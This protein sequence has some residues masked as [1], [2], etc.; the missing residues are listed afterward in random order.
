MDYTA[1]WRPGEPRCCGL[2]RAARTRILQRVIPA[3][4]PLSYQGRA[5]SVRGRRAPR[6]QAGRLNRN[7]RPISALH[8]RVAH[9]P[10]ARLERGADVPPTF[11][12]RP[13]VAV[14][15]LCWL[16]PDP[17]SAAARHN[18]HTQSYAALLTLPAA[19]TAPL[20]SAIPPLIAGQT[21]FDQSS[22][23]AVRP[24]Q[25]VS[26]HLVKITSLPTNE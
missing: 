16:G 13:A 25:A 24:K 1:F 14:A 3:A 6:L 11:L 19:S 17:A 21:V 26:L 15:V 5:A 22:G 12:P 18:T 9:L 8:P 7:P 2:R 4:P 20:H 10:A 23:E